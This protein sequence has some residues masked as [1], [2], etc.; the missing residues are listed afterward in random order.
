MILHLYPIL[1]CSI[2]FGEA[3]DK[4]NNLKRSKAGTVITAAPRDSESIRQNLSKGTEFNWHQKT[5]P[6]AIDLC[7][8]MNS[9]MQTVCGMKCNSKLHSQ[10]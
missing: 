2:Y 1:W 9:A 7:Y 10:N 5:L 4:I 8:A 6:L 3:I